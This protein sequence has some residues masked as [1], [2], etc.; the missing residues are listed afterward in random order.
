MNNVKSIESLLDTLQALKVRLRDTAEPSV[1][2]QL[3][4]AIAEIQK[5]L[6]NNEDSKQLYRISLDVLGKLFNSLPSIVKLIELLSG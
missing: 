1:N 3:D 2:Q 6:E 5:A 4:Q